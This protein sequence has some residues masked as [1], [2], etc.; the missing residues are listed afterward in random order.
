MATT[1]LSGDCGKVKGGR[2]SMVRGAVGHEKGVSRGVSRITGEGRGERRDR[3][4]GE[5]EERQ[6][7]RVVC[8]LFW[9]KQAA[10][11]DFHRHSGVELVI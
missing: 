4:A 10:Q 3:G 5:A 6:Q 2:D 8:R 9:R 1:S 11:E 7:R